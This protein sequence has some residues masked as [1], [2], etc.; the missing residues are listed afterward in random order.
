VLVYQ[1]DRSYSANPAPAGRIRERAYGLDIRPLRILWVKADRLLPVHNG[2]NIR[3]YHIARHLASR[4]ELTFLSY[5]GGARDPGYEAEMGRLF[6]GAMCVYTGRRGQTAFTRGLDYLLRLPVAAPYAVSRFASTPVRQTLRK[7]FDEGS[8]DVAVC[9]FLDAAVNFPHDLVI[10]TVLFQHNVETEIWRRHV[11]TEPSQLKK[12]AYGIEFIKMLRYER[13]RVRKFQHVIAVSDHDQRL[14]AA[15][16]DASR[17]TV[18]PTGV[19]LEQY[20]PEPSAQPAEPLVMFVGAMDWEPNVDAVEYFC[21][22]VWPAVT[23]AM[24]DA[25]FR[26]VG[27]NPGRRVRR[28]ASG[29]IEVTGSVP[30]VVDHLRQAAVVVVPLRI[31]G[32]TRLKIYEAM[33]AGKA[34]VSTSIG[35]E[36]LDVHHGHDILLADEAPVFAQ[37]VLTLLRDAERRNRYERAAAKLAAQY[38]WPAVGDKFMT[39]LEGLTGRGLSVCQLVSG[40]VCQP[41]ET[42]G[43]TERRTQGTDELTY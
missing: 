28:L 6:P 10:P 21:A 23:A 37:A 15:W 16:V 34:V 25:R 14:M 1:G 3:S 38:D 43:R 40:S 39:V 11:L 19:D 33:A 20:N 31:G 8:F 35:A 9:D 17:I 5:Y 12:L 22:E 27:R 29:P 2:G 26:I 7:W 42:D 32:G 36:G 30:S 41:G 18:V 24:P 4:H 13:I